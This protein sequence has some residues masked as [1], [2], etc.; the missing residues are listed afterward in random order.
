MSNNKQVDLAHVA[1]ETMLE[2]GFHPDIPAN[3]EQE[4]QEINE[5]AIISKS[6][7]RD[8]RQTLWSS[9]DNA[10]SR[11]ASPVPAIPWLVWSSDP[12]SELGIGRAADHLSPSV[13]ND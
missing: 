7:V 9:I 2:E 3:A 13:R 1:R 11:G 5:S 12:C 6:T 4:A 8:L 10:T